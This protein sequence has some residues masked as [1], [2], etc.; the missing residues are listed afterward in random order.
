[1]EAQQILDDDRSAWWKAFAEMW[2][3]IGNFYAD[4]MGER[5]AA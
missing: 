2:A 1:M 5:H 3:D 4:M